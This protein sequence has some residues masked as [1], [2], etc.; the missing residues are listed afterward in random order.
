MSMSGIESTTAAEVGRDAPAQTV[1]EPEANG[2][3]SW[4]AFAEEYGIVWVTLVALIVA[5][6]VSSDFLSS[7]NIENV[8]SQNAPLGLVAIGMTFVMIAGGFDLSAGAQV[9]ACTVVAATLSNHYST[10]VAVVG[11]VV[12]GALAGA[13]NGV[14]I[15]ALRINAFVATLATGSIFTGAALLYT[16]STTIPIKDTGFAVIGAGHVF[17]V[18]TSAVIVVVLFVVLGFL[19]AKSVYGRS[20]YAVGGNDVA[21][22]LAGLR[23]DLLRG[24][25]YTLVG[26]GCGAAGLIY[27]SLFATGDPATGVSITLDAIT[28]V[29]I[30]GTSLYG[31]AGAMWRT[32]VGLILLSTI[33]NVFD[34][35]AIESSWQLVTK[36]AV[37]I[38]A[39]GL[40][41]FQRRSR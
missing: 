18:R 10:E 25:T 40:D 32:A 38:L 21:A 17:G 4:R 6:L 26:A 36:G 13:F 39:V 1:Q 7:T 31:G 11:T 29:I 19:L 30:G 2:R 37:L 16:K 14:L 34:L 33:T 35:L 23:V 22:R 28:V 41:L 24:S 15:T 12:A 8:L 20:L 27:A 3:R 9:G 5:S